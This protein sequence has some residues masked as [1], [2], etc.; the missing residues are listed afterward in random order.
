MRSPIP[1]MCLPTEKAYAIQLMA[2]D[3]A[4]PMLAVQAQP[5]PH[6]VNQ[7]FGRSTGFDLNRRGLGRGSDGRLPTATPFLAR[8]SARRGTPALGC[9]ATLSTCFRP[10]IHKRFGANRSDQERVTVLRCKNPG[11]RPS[12]ARPGLAGIGIPVFHRT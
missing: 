8:T 1:H 9:H 3:P 7:L 2:T 5:S 12:V 6:L 4:R 11:W 10:P